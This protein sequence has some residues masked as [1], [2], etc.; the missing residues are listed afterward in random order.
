MH[1]Y[2]GGCV[3]ACLLL[4]LLHIYIYIYTKKNYSSITAVSTFQTFCGIKFNFRGDVPAR[5]V[6]QRMPIN[7]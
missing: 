1:I 4:N 6:V 7:G 5:V 2:V 3:R